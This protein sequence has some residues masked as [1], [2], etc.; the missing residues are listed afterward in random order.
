MVDFNRWLTEVF[1]DTQSDCIEWGPSYGGHPSLAL[2][3]QPRHNTALD[4]TLAFDNASTIQLL[5]A[6]CE[7]YMIRCNHLQT[8]NQDLETQQVELK[9]QLKEALIRAFESQQALDREREVLALQSRRLVMRPQLRSRQRL[10]NEH[11]KSLHDQIT[12]AFTTLDT[13][14]RAPR[15]DTE[16]TPIG[17]SNEA[18]DSKQDCKVDEDVAECES[19]ELGG[20][21]LDNL[22]ESLLP[23]PS[24]NIYAEQETLQ[25][26]VVQLDS[27]PATSSVDMREPTSISSDSDYEQL[28]KLRTDQGSSDSWYRQALRTLKEARKRRF[29]QTSATVEPSLV[30][31]FTVSAVCKE[32]KAQEFTQLVFTRDPATDGDDSMWYRKALQHLKRERTQ[33]LSLQDRAESFNSAISIVD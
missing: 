25:L 27:E 20:A 8:T 22:E 24:K 19:I 14:N 29:K 7:Y 1:A 4:S 12:S 13:I 2:D 6:V 33:R 15:T 9:A 23:G 16:E 5:R 28:T 26:S 3:E 21:D 30:S 31:K 10:S 17:E 18:I 32:A 11:P